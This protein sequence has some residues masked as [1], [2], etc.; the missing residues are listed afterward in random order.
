MRNP[1]AKRPRE[2]MRVGLADVRLRDIIVHLGRWGENFMRRKMMLSG[3]AAVLFICLPVMAQTVPMAL[4]QVRNDLQ[5]DL[6]GPD[7]HDE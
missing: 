2:I 5:R 4:R 1:F 7:E 3:A 6:P